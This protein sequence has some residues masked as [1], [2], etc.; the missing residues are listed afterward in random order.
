M[1]NESH[2]ESELKTWLTILFCLIIVFAQGMLAFTVVGD[3]GQ[4]S[5]AFRPVK[6][7]PGESPYAIYKLLPSPQH[8][9]GEKG[10]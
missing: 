5:W 3:L 9:R 2:K 1:N 6:D 8:V 7:V 4:P 10:E